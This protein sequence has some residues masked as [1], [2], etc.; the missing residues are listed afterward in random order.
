M[1]DIK[2]V[3]DAC[4]NIEHLLETQWGGHG[5]G[6]HK[7]MDNA[8]Y[9]VPKPLVATIRWLATLRNKAVHEKDF[10]IPN[11]GQ[12]LA[13]ARRV[14]R[15]L[16]EALPAA[17]R[18]HRRLKGLQIALTVTVLALL[19]L[20][21]L[22][23]TEPA[24]AAAPGAPAHVQA[25]PAQPVSALS[26]TTRG[27]PNAVVEFQSIAFGLGRDRKP[28]VYATVR[29]TSG[30][31]LSSLTLHARLYL[32]DEATPVADT[33]AAN[34]REQLYVFF[35]DNGLAPGATGRFSVFSI[36]WPDTFVVPDV[37]NAKKRLLVLRVEEASDGRKRT[38][39]ARSA[40]WS[41]VARAASQ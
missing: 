7:K 21:F 3:L 40:P 25:A 23:R 12:Y 33:N 28:E 5:S 11:I 34:S 6:L 24:P 31:T 2:H 30:T 1:S 32:D 20:M 10:E 13:V 8:T 39:P 36:R 29:N 35:G 38:L 26:A 14:E 22:P 15:E 37:L 19:A 18:A 16:Q 4:K 17:I 27:L 41:Q 9:R